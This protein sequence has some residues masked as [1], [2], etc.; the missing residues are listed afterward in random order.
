MFTFGYEN[1]L[2]IDYNLQHSCFHCAGLDVNDVPPVNTESEVQS[3][4]GQCSDYIDKDRSYAGM[5][6]GERTGG[7]LWD[8]FRREDSDKIQDYLRKHA[9]EFRHIFCNPVKQVLFSLHL[10]ALFFLC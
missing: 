8:I 10:F 3:G 2:T 9:T 4:A 7:A 5:H 1:C 6:N